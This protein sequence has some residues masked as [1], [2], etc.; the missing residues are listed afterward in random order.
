MSVK[1]TNNATT[2]LSASIGTTDLTLSVLAATGTQFPNLVAGDWF[3]ATLANAAGALEIVKVTSKAGDVFTIVRAQD[4][5]GAGNWNPGDKVELRP[6]AALFNDK[7]GVADAAA[8]YSPIATSQW[9]AGRNRIHNGAM[10]VAQLAATSAAG[11]SNNWGGPDRFCATNGGA[12]GSFSQQQASM[13]A[14]QGINPP[15]ISQN[16]QTAV[17]NLGGSLYWGGIHQGIEGFDCFDMQGQPVAISF[18]FQAFQAGNY[19]VSLNLGTYSY[20][21][22]FAY[23]VSGVVQKIQVLLPAIPSAVGIPNTNVSAMGIYIGAQNGGTF[24][25]ATLNAWQAGNFLCA[26]TATQWGLNTSGYIAVAQLQIEMGTV[27]TPFEAEDVVVTV[28]KCLRYYQQGTYRFDGVINNGIGCSV[29]V[30]Y[31]VLMRASPALTLTNQGTP[32]GFPTSAGP[33][34]N[35]DAAGFYEVRTGTATGG[36]SY[37]TSFTADARI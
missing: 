19:S 18:L 3:W 8:Q 27:C 25:T 26:S 10:R 24:A 35:N 6:T 7:L 29:G 16:V 9:V 23:A 17:A 5:T 28:T 11:T 22:N 21:M 37:V 31:P 14:W 36:A 15:C 34:A 33:I 13:N 1:V 2:T 20:V 4:G 12:G 32:A 30:R